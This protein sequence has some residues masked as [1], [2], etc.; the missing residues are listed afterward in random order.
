MYITGCHRLTLSFS[1]GEHVAKSSQT[2][3]FK[4]IIVYKNPSGVGWGGGV[5]HT[6]AHIVCKKATLFFPKKIK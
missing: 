2:L 3:G 4:R 6:C 1:G 5:N